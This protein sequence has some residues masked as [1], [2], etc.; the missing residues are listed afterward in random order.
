MTGDY[1]IPVWKIT[2]EDK[3]K[4]EFSGLKHKTFKIIAND[5]YKILSMYGVRC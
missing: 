5:G 3:I 4:L 1:E 2:V